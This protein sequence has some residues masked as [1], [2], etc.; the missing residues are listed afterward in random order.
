MSLLR[1]VLLTSLCICVSGSAAIAA[2]TLS[3][4]TLAYEANGKTTLF[5]AEEIGP[6]KVGGSDMTFAVLDAKDAQKIGKKATLF[7]FDKDGK[8][9]YEFSP[10]PDVFDVEQC[11]AVSLS[12]RRCSGF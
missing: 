4:G 2:G 9:L 1:I 8:L 10:S 3:N 7:F 5:T 12:Q 6:G 11:A